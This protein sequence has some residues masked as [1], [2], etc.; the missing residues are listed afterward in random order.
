MGYS[1]LWKLRRRKTIVILHQSDSVR[2]IFPLETFLFSVHRAQS[3]WLATTRT[4]YD[5]PGMAW[6]MKPRCVND[7]GMKQYCLNW[8]LLLSGGAR[9]HNWLQPIINSSC[10]KSFY[11]AHVHGR[12]RKFLVR[13]CLVITHVCLLKCKRLLFLRE[14]KGRVEKLGQLAALILQ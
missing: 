5:M 13:H 2:F 8:A 11:Y 3:A 7:C 14:E 12:N 9:S 10:T 6:I 1:N 4:S